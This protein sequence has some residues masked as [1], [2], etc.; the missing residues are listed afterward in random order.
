MPSRKA[1]SDGTKSASE[2]AGRRGHL[3]LVK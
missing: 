3:M 1:I 2:T